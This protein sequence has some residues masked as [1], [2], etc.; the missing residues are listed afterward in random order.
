MF[1]NH[2]DVY[3]TFFFKAQIMVSISWPSLCNLSTAEVGNR[4]LHWLHAKP[5][6]Q[7]GAYLRWGSIKG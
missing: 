5:I 1:P 3:L 6:P 4:L 7:Q 2:F